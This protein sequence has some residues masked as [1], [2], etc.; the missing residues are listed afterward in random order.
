[1]VGKCPGSCQDTA[2]RDRPFN[3]DL[4]AAA[5]RIYLLTSELVAAGS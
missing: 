2:A 3:A 4:G 5:E 1:M